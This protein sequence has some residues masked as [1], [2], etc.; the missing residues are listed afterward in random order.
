MA[1]K[2]TASRMAWGVSLDGEASDLED[3]QEALKHPFDPWVLA[4]EGELILR[5]SLLNP[6]TTS[7]E[8]YEIAKVLMEQVN[9]ALGV[10]HRARAVRLGGLTEFLSDG[11]RRSHV[12]AQFGVVEMGDKVRAVVVALGPNGKPKPTPPPE[13]SNPQRWLSI[14][15]EDDLLADALTYFARGDGWFRH[16]QGIGVPFSEVRRRREGV[17]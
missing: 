7:S 17:S 4:T 6:T 10:S 5:S 1:V 16:F 13:P 3:W 2:G 8:A 14:A 11:T 12:F 9:G 15:A